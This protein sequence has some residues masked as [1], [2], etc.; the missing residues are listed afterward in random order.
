MDFQPK[1]GNLTSVY[2]ITSDMA[3]GKEIT[4]GICGPSFY[5]NLPKAANYVPAYGKTSAGQLFAVRQKTIS[6]K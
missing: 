4:Q 3:M 2:I 6:Q 1:G 5:R